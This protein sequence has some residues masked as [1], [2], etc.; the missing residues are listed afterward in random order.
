MSLPHLHYSKL[1]KW[2][3]LKKY[4]TPNY[5]YEKLE[6]N[7]KLKEEHLTFLIFTLCFHIT[8]TSSMIKSKRQS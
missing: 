8:I 4:N 5:I 1:L 7:E 6:K 2:K 3:E